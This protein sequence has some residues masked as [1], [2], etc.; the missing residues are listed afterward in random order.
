ME[1]RDGA[2]RTVVETREVRRRTSVD[3][4]SQLGLDCPHERL[5]PPVNPT[6]LPP[7]RAPLTPTT[8][9]LPVCNALVWRIFGQSGDYTRLKEYEVRDHPIEHR[10]T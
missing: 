8:A 4:R 9:C 3:A 6:D 2:G 10:G 7:P 1:L 5:L